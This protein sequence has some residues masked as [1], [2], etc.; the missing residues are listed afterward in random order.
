MT[1]ENYS[2]FL[3]NLD[4]ATTVQMG[5]F[6][7]KV[8]HGMEFYLKV[9]ISADALFYSWRE[10]LCALL[11][12]RLLVPPVLVSPRVPSVPGS[13]THG[14]LLQSARGNR[15]GLVKNRA[16]YPMKLKS[17]FAGGA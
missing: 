11:L 10:T 13:L 8:L 3:A 1:R 4:A 6:D 9:R 17:Y 5:I 15:S 12:W 16:I 7:G 14:G 2:I